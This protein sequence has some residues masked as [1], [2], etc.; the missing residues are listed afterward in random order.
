MKLLYLK[1]VITNQYVKLYHKTKYNESN[2]S[3]YN[4]LKTLNLS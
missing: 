3:K 4:S 2:T 1:Y